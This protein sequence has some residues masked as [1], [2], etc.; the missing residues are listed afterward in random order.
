LGR[1]RRCRQAKRI[2]VEREKELLE[3][4]SFSLSTPLS[5]SP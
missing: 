4:N 5:P 1:E 3:T 2:G